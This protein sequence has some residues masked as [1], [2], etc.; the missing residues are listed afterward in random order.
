M[1]NEPVPVFNINLQKNILK[2]KNT[3]KRKYC[4][5]FFKMNHCAYC[6]IF[7]PTFNSLIEQYKGNPAVEFFVAYNTYMYNDLNLIDAINK[8][9]SDEYN[10]LHVEGFPTIAI[11]ESD[12]DFEYYYYCELYL[13]QRDMLPQYVESLINE[14][15]KL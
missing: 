10:T 9:K 4:V 7:Q 5:I 14:T 12:P 11:F 3:G 8:I 2:I 15:N 1:N 13:G 6:E